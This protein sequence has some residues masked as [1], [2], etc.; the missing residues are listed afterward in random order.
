MG[1]LRPFIFSMVMLITLNAT[2][3]YAD[4]TSYR[5]NAVASGSVNITKELSNYLLNN[6]LNFG[7]RKQ[8]ISLDWANTWVYGLQNRNITNNDYTGTFNCNLYQGAGKFYYW[9][10]A[11][12]TTSVSLKVRGQYQVGVGAAYSFV[13][14][15]EYYFNISEGVIFEQSDIVKDDTTR[16]IYSTFRNSLR[17]SFKYTFGHVVSISGTGYLQNSLQYAGDYIAKVN[18]AASLKLKKW[19][20][21]TTAL[22]FNRIS[23]TERENFLFTY[24][25]V[26][27]KYY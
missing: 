1:I 2:G 19:L 20:S 25:V 18:L 26:I 11:N 7:I 14:D 15:K 4:S 3:Q 22:Q 13:D 6:A 8:K 27:D 5:I 12:Y 21:F 16:E 10:L 24:G 17:V 23:R 9:G